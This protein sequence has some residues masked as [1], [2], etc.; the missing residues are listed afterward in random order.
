MR[1][2]FQ[3]FQKN[4][5]HSQYRSFMYPS[6]Y[7]SPHTFYLTSKIFVVL[8]NVS[9][10]NA[11]WPGFAIFCSE[12]RVLMHF[13]YVR[14]VP[15]LKLVILKLFLNPYPYG[16]NWQIGQGKWF[17]NTNLFLIWPFLITKFDCIQIPIKLK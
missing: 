1:K 8:N 14:Y 10:T 12:S 6:S 3:T 16:V 5:E 15:Q 4:Y 11:L 9:H 2:R 17:L 13:R 7:Y